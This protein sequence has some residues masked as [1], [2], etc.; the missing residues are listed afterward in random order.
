MTRA[1]L[2]IRADPNRHQCTG[3]GVQWRNLRI[4]RSHLRQFEALTGLSSD[5][6]LHL[7]YPHVFGFPLLMA[8]IT[9]PRYPLPI[10][11]ALQTRNHFLHHRSLPVDARYDLSTTALRQRVLAK[12][13]EVDLHTQLMLEGACAW[14]GLTTFYYR[15]RYGAAE[16]ESSLAS[17]PTLTPAPVRCWHMP[18]GVGLAFGKLTG[19]FNGIHIWNAYARRFGFSGAFH[20]PQ[21]VLAQCASRL[22]DR[23][24]GTQDHKDRGNKNKNEKAQRLDA[25]LKG[26]VFYDTDVCLSRQSGAEPDSLEFSVTP[27]GEHRPAIVG[28]YRTGSADALSLL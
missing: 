12:G 23:H 24:S 26:P 22:P 11:Q 8:L 10:W 21:L 27:T 7:I 2:P 20:H 3:M 1:M 17:S 9:H 15:G 4:D 18:S 19:D 6:G 16:P 14:E 5:S 25:W 28:R 13:L